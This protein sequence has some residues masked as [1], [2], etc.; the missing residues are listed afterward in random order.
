MCV[1]FDIMDSEDVSSSVAVSFFCGVILKITNLTC[2][3][4]VF[5]EK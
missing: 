5:G 3:A 2:D 1:G 4:D